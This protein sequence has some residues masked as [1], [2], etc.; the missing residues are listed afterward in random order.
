MWE[1]AACVLAGSIV[2]YRTNGY[3]WKC[4]LN[5]NLFS[6]KKPLQIHTTQLVVRET[7]ENN[8][9]GLRTL[10]KLVQSQA[11]MQTSIGRLLIAAFTQKGS[12]DWRTPKLNLVKPVAKL[13]NLGFNAFTLWKRCGNKQ[14]NGWNIHTIR[15]G[16]RRVLTLK[17]Q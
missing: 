4:T 2:Q 11:H 14:T 15:S 6:Q 16:E 13:I 8:V 7:P 12:C 9:L 3:T 5:G 1:S 10:A 17:A